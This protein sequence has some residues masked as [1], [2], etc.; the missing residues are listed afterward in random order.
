MRGDSSVCA[1]VMRFRAGEVRF[2]SGDMR[3]QSRLQRHTVRLRGHRSAHSAAMRITS[4]PVRRML[5]RSVAAPRGE[6]RLKSRL[7]RHEVRLRGHRS[8]HPA[9]MPA[10]LAPVCR[11][12][13]PAEAAAK[14]VIPSGAAAPIRPLHRCM[15]APEGSILSRTPHHPKRAAWVAAIRATPAPVRPVR[16]AGTAHCL[17]I[18]KVDAGRAPRSRSISLAQFARLPV[19]VAAASAAGEGPLTPA[20]P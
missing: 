19:V 11:M 6:M 12:H 18:G 20:V 7:Q 4:A 5:G 1:G 13:G 16:S 15:A 10:I 14:H 9:A 8:A 17:T 2:R 3:L